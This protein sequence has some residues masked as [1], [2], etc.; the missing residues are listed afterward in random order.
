MTAAP[1]AARAARLLRY[2]VRTPMLAWHLLV[3]LPITL[4][5]MSP[6][7]GRIRVGGAD[8]AV[9]DDRLGHRMVRWWQGGLMRVFG[10]RIHRVG[11]PLP[12]AV[13]FVAN[14]VSWIDI[15]AL[16]SYRMMGFVAKREIASWPVV[17]WLATM[18]ET[19]YH[20]R[21]S[22]ESL[23]GVLDEMLA[24]L[25]DGRAVGVF[26]EGRTRSGEEIGPFHARIFLA[27]VEAE[28]P[29][30]PVA[31][32]YGDG[33]SRQTIIAFGPTENFAANVLRLL[34]EPG[35]RVEVVFLEPIL[36]GDA[37][38]RRRL[39]DTARSRIVDAMGAG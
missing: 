11:T 3:H 30:Q 9:R 39:A 5:L 7:F 27:A 35:C 13:M 25:R 28:V 16:H 38:G 6:P 32:R 33:A 26:P 20:Q 36:P 18:G 10:F 34:G 21:G 8:G 1:P 31:L 12:G 23:G 17:G 22:Q 19:I 29:V 15:T 37:E 24:R 14:H 2:C 4:I